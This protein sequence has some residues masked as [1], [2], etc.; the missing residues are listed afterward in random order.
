MFGMSHI[1][2]IWIFVGLGV[3]VI[4]FLMSSMARLYRKAGPHEALIVYGLG[5]TRV[6]KGHGTLVFPMVQICR[7][8]PRVDSKTMWRPSGAQ[9]GRSLR[10]ESRVISTSCRVAA[11]MM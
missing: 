11:S 5:G 8:P 4:L 1:F 10:P 9:L 7:E 6:V 3:M 2:E